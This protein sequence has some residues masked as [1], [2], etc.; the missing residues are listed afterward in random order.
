MKEIQSGFTRTSFSLKNSRGFTLIELLVVVV[1]IGI[2]A[3]LLLPAFAG[4]KAKA[5]S[6]LC[7][8]NLRQLGIALLVYTYDNQSYP[9][10][11]RLPEVSEARGSKWYDDIMPKLK[12]GWE[13]AVYK[14][15]GYRGV[16]YDCPPTL[17]GSPYR[18]IGSYA[19]S[20]GSACGMH[21]YLYGLGSKSYKGWGDNFGEMTGVS[22]S[23]VVNPSNMIAL[24]DSIS[25]T[26]DQDPAR[27]LVNGVDFLS[28][29]MNIYY[30]PGVKGA[31]ERHRKMSNV[32]FADGHVE[33]IT[34]KKLFFDRNE[35]SL[36]RWYTDNQPHDELLGGK[37]SD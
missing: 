22:E 5:Q 23:E 16:V 21:Q 26:Y 24:G 3:S 15:P 25:R 20:G 13:N 9:L 1:I 29:S 17:D 10:Y 18:S 36:R 6:G 8:N 28:R 7:R 12:G 35:R 33:T 30:L 19:Y 14:C 37:E 34:F 11:G 31:Q 2:L 27:V 32:T 4:A